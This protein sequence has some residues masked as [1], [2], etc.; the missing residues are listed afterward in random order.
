M[1][2]MSWLF[3]YTERMANITRKHRGYLAENLV[4]TYYKG[5]WRLVKERNRTIRGGEIDLIVENDKERCFVEVKR[6]DYLDDFAGMVGWKKKTALKR[7]VVTYNV[8]HPT[9]KLPRIDVVFVVENTIV[10]L[11]ENVVL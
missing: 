11:V 9:R 10:H 5:K 6:S 8:Q 1:L 3:C 4:T 2:V 7:A